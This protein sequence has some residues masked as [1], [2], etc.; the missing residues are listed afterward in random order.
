MSY[1]NTKLN[2]NT[3]LKIS[4][5]V[6]NKKK[7]F[8]ST[9]HRR[10]FTD[11]FKTTEIGRLQDVIN[12]TSS[13]CRKSDVWKDIASWTSSR[14]RKSD[15]F[16]QRLWR[17]L[18]WSQCVV[19]FLRR[20]EDVLKTS[21]SSG[22]SNISKASSIWINKPWFSNVNTESWIEPLRHSIR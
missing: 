11:F 18:V 7:W 17:R 10:R 13:R 14:R 21:V 9:L 2:R 15:V 6:Q 5:T 22:F 8:L 4:Q 3:F 20:P 12:Q 16:L 1:L 19:T